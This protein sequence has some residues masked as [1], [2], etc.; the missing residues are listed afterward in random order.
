MRRYP[1]GRPVSRALRRTKAQVL[2]SVLL[3]GP[4]PTCSSTLPGSS[5]TLKKLR[6]FW[7]STF[8]TCDHL[9][10]IFEGLTPWKMTP[11]SPAHA[12]KSNPRV[13]MLHNIYEVHLFS[14]RHAPLF[15]INGFP[16]KTACE[17]WGSPKF[18]VL[19][20]KM[21]VPRPTLL[22]FTGEKR[23]CRNCLFGSV[24]IHSP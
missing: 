18:T 13:S 2:R 19:G 17:K 5:W 7:P 12:I 20:P 10:T 24:S 9:V 3:V 6:C 16:K 1:Q 8:K 4:T 21:R 14:F 22:L 11:L 15:S 23:M